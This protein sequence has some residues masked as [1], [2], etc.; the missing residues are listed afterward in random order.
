[1]NVECKYFGMIAEITGTAS[2]SLILND[3]SNIAQLDEQLKSKYHKLHFVSY[4]IAQN[5]QIAD[6]HIELNEKD[7]IA[8]LPPFGGG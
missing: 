3:A 7:E 2:E 6:T 5:Q 8:L 4:Q 1:M